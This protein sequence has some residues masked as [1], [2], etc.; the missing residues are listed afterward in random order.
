MSVDEPVEV[1]MP[2]RKIAERRRMSRLDE[3]WIPRLEDRKPLWFRRRIIEDPN[4][5]KL[6]SEEVGDIIEPTV[7]PFKHE[8]DDKLSTDG[9]RVSIPPNPEQ[10][11]SKKSTESIKEYTT[12]SSQTIEYKTV[13]AQTISEEEIEEYENS[14]GAVIDKIHKENYVS[15]EQLRRERIRNQNLKAV[16]YVEEVFREMQINPYKVNQYEP[17]ESDPG[18]VSDQRIY[19]NYIGSK[20]FCGV[21]S[22]HELEHIPHIIF[23]DMKRYDLPN[24]GDKYRAKQLLPH[25]WIVHAYRN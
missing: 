10:R 16:A 1:Q 2:R 15:D 8:D 13:G 17:C 24:R 6:I 4:D 11:N 20:I 7:P 14:C 3:G 25:V 18:N 5:L 9:T 21:L 22:M 23:L 19:S 12:S